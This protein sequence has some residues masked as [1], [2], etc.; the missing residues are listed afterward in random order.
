MQGPFHKL[1]LGLAAAALLAAGAAQAD[2]GKLALTGGI[3]SIDGAAGGGITP[4]ATIGTLGNDVGVSAAYSNLR[5]QD[6]DFQ[7]YGVAVGIKDRLE[8]SLGKQEL[9]L[10]S[11]DALGVPGRN[12]AN[13]QKS[14]LDI[15]G[16]KYRVAGEAILD[17]DNLMPQISVGILHKR[18]T[19]ST[20]LD[21]YL[22]ALAV[23]RE[24][25]ELYA[26]ASKLFL[27]NSLLLNATARYTKAN[28]NGLLGFGSQAAGQNNEMRLYPE[29]SVAYLLS[30]KLAIGAEYRVKPNNLDGLLAPGALKE[31]EWKDLFVAYTPVKNL[32]LTL[33]YVDLGQVVPALAASRTSSQS[34]AFLSAQIAF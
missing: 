19:A 4:W 29:L 28:Q 3:T 18:V 15:I 20:V 34:G 22:T 23:E 1:A 13:G 9:T 10:K 8:L 27:K 14:N 33:A 25:N 12:G 30:P 16:L 32:T 5:V 7:S 11:V 17:S 2:T 21:S 31:T 26:T 6:Y 24:G